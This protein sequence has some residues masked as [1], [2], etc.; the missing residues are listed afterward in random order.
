MHMYFAHYKH[1]KN[2][3]MAT[4]NLAE[5]PLSLKASKLTLKVYESVK[6]I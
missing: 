2:F 6:S 4:L 1:V 3:L 5:S